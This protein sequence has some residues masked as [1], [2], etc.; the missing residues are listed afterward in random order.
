M[1][2]V[3]HTSAIR[4]SR[5]Q[6]IVLRRQLN[7]FSEAVVAVDGGKFKVNNLAARTMRGGIAV[8]CRA[9]SR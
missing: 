8:S 5:R 7:L 2:V 4:A 6:V 3:P 1:G 9:D